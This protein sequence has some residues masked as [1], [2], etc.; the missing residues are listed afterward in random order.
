MVAQQIKLASLCAS[1]STPEFR[2]K[3]QNNTVFPLR[4]LP[5]I[6]LNVT[7]DVFRDQ[8]KSN[9]PA[10]CFVTFDEV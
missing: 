8:C 3:Y 9:S 6:V 7:E 1:L 4:Y 5:V 2:C 10:A